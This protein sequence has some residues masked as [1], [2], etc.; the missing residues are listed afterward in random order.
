MG[1]AIPADSAMQRQ[2]NSVGDRIC[3]LN[4]TDM[5]L[6]RA[7]VKN[8][9]QHA[10]Y[11]RDMPVPVEADRQYNN[12]LQ[13]GR[14]RTPYAP[15]TQSR[16]VLVENLTPSKKII[17]YNH[18]NKLCKTGQLARAKGQDVQCPGHRG[19]T[20]TISASDNIGDEKRG[21]RE[22]AKCMINGAEPMQVSLMVTDADGC[23]INGF[24]DEVKRSSNI[25]PE[26]A[27]DPVHLN[28]SV[29]RATS[30]GQIGGKLK[31][32]EPCTY[33]QRQQAKNRLADSIAWRAER[34]VRAALA[35]YDENGAKAALAKA[36][37]AVISCYQGNHSLCKKH[38]LVCD[39]VRLVYE[40]LP[41][42][43]HG[44][45]CFTKQEKNVL[46]TALS[47]RM[48]RRGTP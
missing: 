47:K 5:N 10:G 29:T 45:F 1:K 18:E 14:R 11:S 36:I 31:T 13:S 8:T 41:K 22:L 4:T 12:S 2:I 34:E 39:G 37:P 17:A 6:Q 9:L 30:R 3:T 27:L 21:G 48:G 46:T 24:S 40:Y 20:A 43:A 26:H 42:F 7:E 32:P 28:R 44:N 15:A 25:T 23:M 19:C 35:K 33:A 16:D 38:S